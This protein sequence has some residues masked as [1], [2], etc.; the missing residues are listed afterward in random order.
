MQRNLFPGDIQDTVPKNSR[1]FFTSHYY[2]K[3]YS[4]KMQVKFV[5]S[6]NEHVMMSSVQRPSLC[7]CTGAKNC[8]TCENYV[9][10]YKIFQEHQLNSR[11]LPVFSRAISN[12]RRFPGVPGV[13]DTL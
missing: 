3:P 11:R 7:Q 5:M 6:I 12:S 10:N 9:A 8:P 2:N 13:V 1:R 4:I